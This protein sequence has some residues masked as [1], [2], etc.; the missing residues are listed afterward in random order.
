MQIERSAKE[1]IRHL[2]LKSGLNKAYLAFRAARGQNVE[3][4]RSQSLP[5]RFS[6]I[7][8]NR[9]WNNR[10]AGSLSGLGSELENTKAIRQRLPKNASSTS[11]AAILT[12]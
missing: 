1:V 9:V 4:L 12:G 6:A 3:H 10:P 8:R 2:I 11:V 5:E 7:Y